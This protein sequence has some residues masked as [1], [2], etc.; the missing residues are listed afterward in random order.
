MQF[1][2]KNI[3]K[4]KIGE[5]VDALIILGAIDIHLIDNTHLETGQWE[6]SFVNYALSFEDDTRKERKTEQKVWREVME[7]IHNG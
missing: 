2:L 7:E 6:I 3:K 4:E 1:H 5:I